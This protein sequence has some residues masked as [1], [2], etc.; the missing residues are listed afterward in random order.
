M[1]LKLN[2]IDYCKNILLFDEVEQNVF[3]SYMISFVSYHSWEFRIRS[4]KLK[5]I[6]IEVVSDNE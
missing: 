1:K 2:V 5:L 6:C 3:V 4:Y